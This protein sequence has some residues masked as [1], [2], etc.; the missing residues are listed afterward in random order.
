MRHATTQV[1][2]QAPPPSQQALCQQKG[3]KPTHEHRIEVACDGHKGAG[4]CFYM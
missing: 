3:V 1:Q 2:W 4:D